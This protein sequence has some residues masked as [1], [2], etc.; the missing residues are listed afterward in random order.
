M[1]S[2]VA[3][4]GHMGMT[5][6]Y[7][8]EDDECNDECDVESFDEC[9][10]GIAIACCSASPTDSPVATIFNTVTVLLY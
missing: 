7:D 3:M 2:S 8:E 4:S 5:Y 6:S 1:A 10:D 9:N